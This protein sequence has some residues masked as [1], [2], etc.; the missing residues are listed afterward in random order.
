MAFLT[1]RAKDDLVKF[2]A[3]N[4]ESYEQYARYAESRGWPLFTPAYFKVWVQRRR[5]KVQAARAIAE[6]EVR[7]ATILNKQK[8]VELLE[9]QVKRIEEGLL[10]G[11]FEDELKAMDHM[12]KLLQA[13]S[14]ECG[15]WNKSDEESAVDAFN[16]LWERMKRAV[17]EDRRQN[18]QEV[19]PAESVAVPGV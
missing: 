11:A 7:K 10:C 15:E 3:A 14:Q 19:L 2:V 6:L 4:G 5:S 18:A 12:R 16:P 8:R 1:Q 9:L 17:L 13:I